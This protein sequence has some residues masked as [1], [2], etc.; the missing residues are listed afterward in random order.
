MVNVIM[1][2]FTIGYGWWCDISSTNPCTSGGSFGNSSNSP[3]PSRPYL[4]RPQAQTCPRS[5]HATVCFRPHEM[6][7]TFPPGKLPAVH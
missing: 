2:T 1:A 5:S 6:Y 3:V 7:F 4:A